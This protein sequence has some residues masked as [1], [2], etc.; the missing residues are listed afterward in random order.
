MSPGRITLLAQLGTTL[1]LVGLIWL[2]QIVSYPLF[3]KVGR[4]EFASYHEAHARLITFVVGPMM[5]GELLASFAWALLPEHHEGRWVAWLG[6]AL[7][8]ATWIFTFALAVPRHDALARGFDGATIAS[9]ITVN[10]LRTAAWTA[11]GGLLLWALA[12]S[13]RGPNA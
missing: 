2:V 8:I 7:T 9:L 1:P 4:A 3:A 11:R 12:R 10:W 6:L 13:L 5:V